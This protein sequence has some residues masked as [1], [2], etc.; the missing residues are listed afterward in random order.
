MD[1]L[2]INLVRVLRDDPRQSNKKIAQSLEIDEATVQRRVERLVSSGLLKLTALPNLEMFG[3]PIRVYM[4]LQVDHLHMETIKQQLCRTNDLRYV[5]ACIGKADIF[6][7]GDF[8]S[9]ESTL[10]F[11][12]KLGKINGISSIDTMHVYKEL[13]R[14]YLPLETP[15]SETKMVPQINYHSLQ[16]TDFKLILQLQKNAQTPLKQLS[17]TVGLSRST[18]HRRIKYLTESGFIKFAAIMDD[19]KAGFPEPFNL[20]IKTKPDS[21]MEIADRLCKYDYI[22]LVAIIS[23]QTHIWVGGTSR[24]SNDLL[25]Y[26]TQEINKTEGVFGIESI[27]I[28]KIW[29]NTY[30]WLVE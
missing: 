3:F 25:N 12:A 19:L 11:I 26:V 24:S 4:L 29:K 23:G 5:A 15:D 18:I 14:Y 16:P 8:S 6:T 28:L 30:T 10:D 2:D 7:R 20:R 13:K 9:M 21:M 27:D 1:E 17:E 22:S